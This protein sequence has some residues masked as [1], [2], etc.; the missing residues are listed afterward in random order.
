MQDS[1]SSHHTNPSSEFKFWSNNSDG[2][3]YLYDYLNATED[4]E[5]VKS[6]GAQQLTQNPGAYLMRF[7]VITRC[8]F[9][10]GDTY[11]NNET[12]LTKDINQLKDDLKSRT[13]Q[14]YEL[15]KQLAE[16]MK[17]KKTLD[18]QFS[19]MTKQKPL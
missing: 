6:I 11:E 14:V 19:E 10:V 5:K 3:R 1:G 18:S 2:L 13:L 16:M 17:Q 7:T 9:E 15:T 4:V 12:R 8:L